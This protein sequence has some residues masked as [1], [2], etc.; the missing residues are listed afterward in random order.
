MASAAQRR[1]IE[2]L[3]DTLVSS[4]P[5]GRSASDVSSAESVTGTFRLVYASTREPFRSSIFFWAF[6]Q[7]LSVDSRAE[8]AVAAIFRVTGILPGVSARA[9]V[10]EIFE[11]G[12]RSVV[13]LDILGFHGDVVSTGTLERPLIYDRGEAEQRVKVETTRVVDSN[14]LP[15]SSDWIAPVGKVFRAIAGADGADATFR[16]VYGDSEGHVVTV[17]G[18]IEGKEDI[19]V[20]ERVEI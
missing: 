1:E 17:G 11:T 6:K 9:I 3:I 14:Y 18:G 20:Y 13:N 10:H 2:S 19:F 7:A 12:I 5:E 15:V 4:R 16:V 8:A